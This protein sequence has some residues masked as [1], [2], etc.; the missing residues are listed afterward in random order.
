MDEIETDLGMEL[1]GDGLDGAAPTAVSEP[2]LQAGEDG[3]TTGRAVGAVVDEGE[4]GGDFAALAGGVDF[5][6]MMAVRNDP[7]L[8]RTGE[9]EGGGPAEVRF[10]APDGI[11]AHGG[12][13]YFHAIRGFGVAVPWLGRSAVN[14]SSS[15][16]LGEDGGALFVE[17][18]VVAEGVHFKLA[19]HEAA[20]AVEDVAG[21][22]D[23]L[24]HDGG[25][26]GEIDEIDFGAEDAGELAGGFEKGHRIA[27]VRAEKCEV[28]IA[29]GMN[30][31][32][33]AGA[34]DVDELGMERGKFG[35]DDWL[36]GRGIHGACG[37]S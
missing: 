6:P 36:G 30:R 4:A 24:P 22:D 21:A 12:E 5:V 35:A 37:E 33:D 15:G 25:G 14:A 31:A 3:I 7:H 23:F 18:G 2:V 17:P 20:V 34:E 13:E 8:M 10:T 9:G 26:A 19:M 27:G 28:E 1:A 11:A 16:E 32:G 29:A